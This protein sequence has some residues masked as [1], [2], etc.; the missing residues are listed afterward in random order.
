MA[1]IAWIA[2]IVIVLAAVLLW[3]GRDR[4]GNGVESQPSPHAIDQNG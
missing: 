2:L 3:F 1:R 4:S